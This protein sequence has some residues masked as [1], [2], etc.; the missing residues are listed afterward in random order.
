VHG[1]DIK[2]TIDDQFHLGADTKAMTTI[3]GMMVEERS[4]DPAGSGRTRRGRAI[5]RAPAAGR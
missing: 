5:F 1:T 4:I 3:A 2:V